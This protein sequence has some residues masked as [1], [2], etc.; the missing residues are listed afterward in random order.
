MGRVNLRSLAALTATLAL[1]VTVVG[2]APASAGGDHGEGGGHG[3][4]CAVYPIAVKS[5]VLASAST[6]K[7]I[8]DLTGVTPSGHEGWL[9]WTGENGAPVLAKSLTPPGND[10]NYRNPDD[11][12]DRQLSVDDWVRGR[13]GVVSSRD[14]REALDRL[15]DDHIVL[16]VWDVTR[17]T[18]SNVAYHVTG[19]A[20]VEITSYKLTPDNRISAKYLGMSS[21]TTPDARPVAEPATATAVEDQQATITL[22]GRSR[23]SSSDLQ[24]RLTS[25][26]HGTAA[27]V[28]SPDC[29]RSEEGSD[30][31]DS[32]PWG[33]STWGWGRGWGGS[34][35]GG[36]E[37]SESGVTCSATVTY[38]PS[39][40]FNGADQFAFTVSDGRSDSAP[41]AVTI[42]VSE[43]NDPPVAGPD[44]AAG[45]IGPVAIPA[46]DL[47]ANDTA[48]P[49]NESAQ[50]LT[51]VAVT[52]GPG[53]HGTVTLQSGV[54]TYT[55]EA[56]FSGTATF[57]YTVCDDGTTAGQLASLC[58]EGVVTVTVSPPQNQTP[59]AEG[60]TT[61]ATEDTSSTLTLTGSDPDGD[62]LTFAVVSGPA[63][64]T[65][66]GAAP[67]LTY[68]PDPDYFGEDVLTFAVTDGQATSPPAVVSI[69][70]AEVNDPPVPGPD[71]ASGSGPAVAVPVESLLTNDVPGPANE[72]AQT[73]A[74]AEVA[75]GPDTH[76]SVS[77]VDGVITYTPDVGFSGAGVFSYT[78]CD[79]GTT[80]SLPDPLCAATG[81]V[82][83]HLDDTEPAAGG[84][85]GIAR[86]R[87]G[88][89]DAD[90]TR[91]QR[92][93]R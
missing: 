41:A 42:T 32:S 85:S 63:H 93:R 35:G 80:L 61:A 48:G 14:V 47:V 89:G 81:A 25:P 51:V 17:G 70:V 9:T 34:R 16:P 90:H 45:G 92:S 18:G 60:S 71:S 13:P 56:A 62:A 86:P 2:P 28:G 19:F 59:V 76:G 1:A 12:S 44:S 77:L 37:L 5:S 21:C 69:T 33:R 6:G 8:D 30:D 31:D 29:R 91:R 87:R 84:R 4:S 11:P 83:V 55:A 22:T 49:A 26:E 20:N 75:T 54:V 88:H 73:L 15:K 82:T 10:E 40:D 36:S 38:T 52:S 68:T 39:P 79:N 64:G 78:V 67:D 7:V 43:V 50:K 46:A 24:F 57:T 65:V 27:V 58:A 66:T 23:E 72:A 53:T 74:V 3:S